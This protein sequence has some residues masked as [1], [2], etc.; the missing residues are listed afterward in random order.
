MKKNILILL[1]LGQDIDVLEGTIE[2]LVKYHNV[3]IIYKYGYRS[4]Y[5]R[6]NE[7]LKFF[8][9]SIGLSQNPSY[10]ELLN[11][12]F[13]YDVLITCSESNAK[14]HLIARR[15]AIAGNLLNKRTITIQHGYE[16]IGL[17]YSDKEYDI[18]KVEFKSRIILTWGDDLHPGIPLSTKNKCTIAG[19]PKKPA[20]PHSLQL[21]LEENSDHSLISI[22]ENLH[23]SRY[24]DI[25]KKNFLELVFEI[26]PSFEKF[27]FLVK[28]HHAGN[29][30]LSRYKGSIKKS[31]NVQFINPY[32]SNWEPFT[33]TSIISKSKKVI[34][35]PSTV[36]VDA[37]MQ[38]KD[39]SVLAYDLNLGRNY[40][41]TTKIKSNDMVEKF[42][43][44]QQSL[45]HSLNEIKSFESYKNKLLSIISA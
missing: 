36:A 16:N 42:I 33:A 4:Q 30:L 20:P 28:P 27:K 32:D 2:T 9:N 15:L 18:K 39:V 12:L 23:W 14:P 6:S 1:N 22:F 13:K 43:N 19:F 34:T 24:S 8:P 37:L 10:L 35:T 41:F 40:N 7:I 26:C 38:M 3:N 21:P 25:Y 45:S 11:T 5:P 31:K 44:T 29:W 17:T